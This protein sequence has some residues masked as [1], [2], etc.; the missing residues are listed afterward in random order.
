MIYPN[1]ILFIPKVNDYQNVNV[2]D[3]FK[4]K[5]MDNNSTSKVHIVTAGDTVLDIIAK[6]N[7]SLLDFIKLNEHKLLVVGTE[8]I[9]AK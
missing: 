3:N 2:I 8:I 7:L 1:Q 9:I 5:Y 6:Y 4:N